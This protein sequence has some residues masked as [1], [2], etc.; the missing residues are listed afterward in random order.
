MTLSNHL[1]CAI[2]T[3]VAVCLFGGTAAAQPQGR[4]TDAAQA[5]SGDTVSPRHQALFFTIYEDTKDGRRILLYEPMDQPED[6]T[7]RLSVD[8][9]SSI[10]LVPNTRTATGS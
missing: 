6:N 3:L 7:T 1:R 9:E 8:A 2:L 10:V 4:D 5:Q